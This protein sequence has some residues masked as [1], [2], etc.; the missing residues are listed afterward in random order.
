MKRYRS[1]A[2]FSFAEDKYFKGEVYTT[3]PD[4]YAEFFEL[5]PEE[6]VEKKIGKNV[7]ETAS[8]KPKS[9]KR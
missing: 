6:R 4:K 7:V 1:H 2:N 9:K 3:F 8:K 5:L